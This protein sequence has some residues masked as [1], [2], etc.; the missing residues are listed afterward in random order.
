MKLLKKY[1]YN[2]ELMTPLHHRKDAP[3]MQPG[4]DVSCRNQF[5]AN[6]VNFFHF[7]G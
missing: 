3:Q 5:K 1:V 2:T 7:L 4:L 6:Q